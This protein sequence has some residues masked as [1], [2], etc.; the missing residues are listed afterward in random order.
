MDERYAQRI[1]DG[2]G[3]PLGDGSPHPASWTATLVPG[4]T[5]EGHVAYGP[6]GKPAAGVVVLAQG[7]GYRPA[8]ERYT[9]LKGRESG[10]GVT[11]AQGYY[12]I[13]Q[14]PPD[15]YNISVSE[16]RRGVG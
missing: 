15:R 6:T 16:S 11:D 8:G 12:R 13:T 3:V 5:L 1:D 2:F 14:L 7:I 9:P 10:F 4:S